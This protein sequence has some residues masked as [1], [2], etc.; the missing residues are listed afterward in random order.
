MASDRRRTGDGQTQTGGGQT[1]TGGGQTP[2]GGNQATDR[3]TDHLVDRCNQ[4]DRRYFFKRK[5]FPG[6]IIMQFIVETA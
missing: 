2:T 4:E 6:S 3:W 1:Q 5:H